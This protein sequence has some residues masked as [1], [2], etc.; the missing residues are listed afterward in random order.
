MQTAITRFPSCLAAF[1]VLFIATVPY[2]VEGE[3]PQ[4]EKQR[5]LGITEHDNFAE[6]CDTARR[7]VEDK[8]L[9][10][11]TLIDDMDNSVDAAYSAK[12]D[13]VFL[14]RTDGRLAVAGA[15]GPRGFAP[16]LAD[17]KAWLADYSA[18]GEEPV[19]TE[20]QIEIA[21]E[22]AAAR[23]KMPRRR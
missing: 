7:L 21:A 5:S 4:S 16:A 22:R 15:K 3:S 9:T 20:K 23:Q 11:P 19:L 10:V 8:L 18:T 1:V 12:P 14:V 13:R 6:R 17:C 2:A